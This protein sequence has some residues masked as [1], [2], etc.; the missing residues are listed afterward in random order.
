VTAN[1]S[2]D[3]ATSLLKLLPSHGIGGNSHE[4]I[5]CNEGHESLTFFPNKLSSMPFPNF[6]K[7]EYLVKT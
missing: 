5:T 6:S 7:Y 3:P 2:G 1:D 4:E